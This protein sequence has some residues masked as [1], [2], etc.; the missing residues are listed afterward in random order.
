MGSGHGPTSNAVKNICGDMLGADYPSKLP[1]A[2]M[3]KIIADAL[4]KMGPYT[5]E[6]ASLSYFM[7]W[8]GDINL[9]G[10]WH[11]RITF[12]ASSLCSYRIDAL[13]GLV[14]GRRR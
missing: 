11:W 6:M 10:D 12:H 7:R 4:T 1:C 8:G 9:S 3:A 14:D 5:D 13:A 2:Q